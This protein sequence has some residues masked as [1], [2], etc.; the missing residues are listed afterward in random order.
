MRRK[1][2]GSLRFSSMDKE[3][4]PWPARP[5]A[6]YPPTKEPPPRTANLILSTVAQQEMK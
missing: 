6:L 3:G 1:G 5:F 2:R 4:P